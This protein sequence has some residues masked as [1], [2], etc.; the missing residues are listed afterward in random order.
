MALTYTFA[1]SIAVGTYPNQ[2]Q[3]SCIRI[4]AISFNFEAAK[5]AA[6]V[7][8]ASI[9][10]EVPATGHKFASLSVS[11]A[12]CLTLVRN[13]LAGINPNTGHTFE[14][15]ILAKAAAVTDAMSGKVLIPAGTAA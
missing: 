1:Q 2:A 9:V 5:A 4:A 15:D 6:G 8:S 12:A 14:A 13:M 10:L 11:D 3:V 7:A